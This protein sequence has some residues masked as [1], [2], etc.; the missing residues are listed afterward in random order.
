MEMSKRVKIEEALAFMLDFWE[1]EKND[2]CKKKNLEE[3][4]G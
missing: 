1:N 3:G 2:K 4:Y